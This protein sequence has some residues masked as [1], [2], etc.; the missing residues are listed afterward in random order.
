MN[1]RVQLKNT[2]NEEDEGET[3]LKLAKQT[4]REILVEKEKKK[5]EAKLTRHE[6]KQRK[7][8]KQKK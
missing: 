5:N 2:Q 1:A 7:S 6:E 3:A 8:I 4:D